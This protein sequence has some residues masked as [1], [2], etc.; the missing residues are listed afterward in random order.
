MKPALQVA[1]GNA[2]PA[3]VMSLTVTRAQNAGPGLVTLL[4]GAGASASEGD[5]ATVELGYD[6]D[7]TL[8]FTG[9]VS[10]VE[11][12]LDGVRV[13]CTGAHAK[14]AQARTET[15]YVQQTAGGVVQALA[16][17]AGVEVASVED[18]IDLPLYVA[19]AGRSHHAHCL[20]LARWC[21]FDLTEDADGALRFGAFTR[22]AADHTFRFGADVLSAA[23]ELTAAEEATTVIPESPASSQGDETAAW[24][25]KTPHSGGDG[26]RIVSVSALRTKDAADKAAQA[27][28]A[29]AQRAAATG[30]IELA[31]AP[32]VALGDAVALE[33]MPAAALDRTYQVLGLRHA[34]DR[35]RGFRTQ[36]SIGAA[37]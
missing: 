12:R 24:L 25:V 29:F 17:D 7:T 20:R 16:A 3:A 5:P 11:Y 28:V 34:L 10:A 23:L 15:T 35:G 26:P 18:G 6:G 14:L 37:P 36:L 30:R 1:L 4:L 2:S 9:S 13:D 33:G 21:G 19:D 27:A 31:G 8:V 22:S 32:Q